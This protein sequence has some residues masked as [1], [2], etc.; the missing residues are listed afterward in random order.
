MSFVFIFEREEEALANSKERVNS[1][2][3]RKI[4]MCVLFSLQI[5]GLVSLSFSQK[6]KS[7]AE[8]DVLVLFIK[9]HKF[10]FYC[11]SEKK[12][13]TILISIFSGQPLF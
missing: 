11:N 13:N 4:E 1:Q 3:K 10:F 2:G 8:K 7:E 6:K 12:S 9:F 5:F